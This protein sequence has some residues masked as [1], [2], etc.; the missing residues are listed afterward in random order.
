MTLSAIT[1]STQ[2]Y[3]QFMLAKMRSEAAGGNLT[4]A[5]EAAFRSGPFNVA[6]RELLG[7]YI[8]LEE[9]YM[10]QTGEFTESWPKTHEDCTAGCCVVLESA[11]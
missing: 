11:T 10:N 8:V 7:S 3:N 5:R 1:F 4:N 2:E 9:Y 6:L